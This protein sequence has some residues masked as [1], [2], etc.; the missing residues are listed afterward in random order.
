MK[1]LTSLICFSLIY[2][3]VLP[4]HA[5]TE[6]PVEILSHSLRLTEEGSV[7]VLG[8]VKNTHENPLCFVTISIEYLSESGKPLSVERFTYE[9]AGEMPLDQVMASRSLI[10]PGQTS[11]FERVRDVSKVEGQIASCKVTATG[12]LLRESFASA[13]IA[14]ITTT[15]ENTALRIKGTF[16]ATGKNPCKNPAVVVAGYNQEGKIV[17]H[18]TLFITEDGTAYG[19]PL[20]ALDPNQSKQFA[21]LLPNP[22]EQVAEVKVFPNFDCD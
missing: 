9:D 5:Q 10:P 22:D 15:P 18:E 7:R 11:P 20:N 6:V 4:T 19:A 17:A 16:T 13:E 21:L 2:A 1:K 12:L 8:E 3:S 14:D